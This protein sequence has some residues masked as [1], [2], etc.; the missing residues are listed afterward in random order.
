VGI[1]V[2]QSIHIEDFWHSIGQFCRW[3]CE[4]AEGS[5]DEP[6]MIRASDADVVPEP[7]PRG[8]GCRIALEAVLEVVEY[9]EL[10]SGHDI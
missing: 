5:F 8:N 3:P 9:G 6:A 2:R 10:I 4:M 1:H 7:S